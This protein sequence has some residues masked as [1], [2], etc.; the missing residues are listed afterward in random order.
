[1]GDVREWL[2][3]DV[4]V[5]GCRLHYQRIHREKP[6]IVL[7]HGIT[8]SGRCWMPMAELLAK[9]Y[10]V[11][12]LDAVG[13]GRSGRVEGAY[14]YETLAD[15][16]GGMVEDLGIEKPLLMGHSMGASTVAMLAAQR[17]DVPGAILL[18]DPGWRVTPPA[19]PPAPSLGRGRRG[20]PFSRWI[21]ILQ[22]K[23]LD[24]VVAH[25]R[26]SNPT[27]AEAEL[28]PWAESKL[29]F[30]L[31]FFPAMRGTVSSYKDTVSRITCPMLLMSGDTE[32]GGIVSRAVGENCR[33]MWQNKEQS[34][35]I[36]IEEAGHNIR[37]E[38]FE[39]FCDEVFR[40]LSSLEG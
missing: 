2:E 33:E 32:R 27:W 24:D 3:G 15:H 35:W 7:L 21:G 38:R 17:P 1:M 8:D 4:V 11:I 26:Q 5:D 37:R 34:R 20:S 29:Q 31:S 12:M 13:H 23:S 30:D 22:H 19:P 14:T 39:A 36:R 6:S 10:D 16:L 28:L 18:E 40:F 9:Q 25:C